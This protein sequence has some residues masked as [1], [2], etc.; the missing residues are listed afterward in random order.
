MMQQSFIRTTR[1]FII[2]RFNLR[3]EQAEE[4]E[5]IESVTKNSDFR[6]ANVWTLIFAILIAS[7]GLNM[8]SPA[9]IIG[10]MLISP[11]MGPVM[12]IGLGIGINHFSLIKKGARNLFIATVVSLTASTLYFL[13]TPLHDARSELLAQTAPS[14]WDVLIALFGGMAG[15]IAMTRKVKGN[16]ITGVAIATTLMP[17]LCT[18]GYGL[19]TGNLYY[20]LGAMYMY[21]INSVFICL[22]TF[23]I[24]RLMRFKK[25]SLNETSERKV[26]RYILFTVII[27]VLP[28]I[29]ITYGII[30]KSIFE[31][32]AGLFV[33]EQFRFDNTLVVSKTFDYE[34]RRPQIDLLVVGKALAPQTI[35]SLRRNLARYELQ[36]AQLIVRQGLN[37]RK[38]ID[39]SQIRAGILKDVQ[40]I[41]SIQSLK[42]AV[43]DPFPDLG[44]ELKVL[45]PA[46]ERYSLSH[47]IVHAP[48]RS[49]DTV[50]L[51]VMHFSRPLRQADRYKLSEWLKKRLAVDSLR[52]ILE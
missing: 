11:L 28:S 34:A 27:T 25:V 21:F 43:S 12:G 22:S 23:M 51:A 33:E 46:A 42:E 5:V 20:F 40:R 50:T 41:D 30:R 35:D 47:A 49:D 15:V 13:I 37:A 24:I 31:H 1:R 18:A 44:P 38:E 36:D 8:N 2:S 32:N 29:Y 14:I 9:V 3:H 4:A 19:A 10:A 26:P 17:P 6:G 45:Y 7:I 48:G 16:A 39:I 52:L